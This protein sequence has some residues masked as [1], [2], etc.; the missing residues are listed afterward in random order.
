MSERYP[1]RKRDERVIRAV[2]RLLKQLACSGVLEPAQLVSA[3]KVLHVLSR[4]PRTTENVCVT[5]ELSWQ[6]KQEGCGSTS[7]WQFSV[8]SD[9]LNLS[10]G[11]SEYT[12]GVGSDSFTTMSWSARLGERTDYDGSWD[13]SWMQR[14][15]QSSDTPVHSE[16]FRGCSISVD[17]DDNDLL[18]DSESS[19]EEEPDISLELCRQGEKINLSLNEWRA[20]I[21]AFKQSGWEAGGDLDVYST[22]GIAIGNE[23]GLAMHEAGNDL[24][25]MIDQNPALAQSVG[26]DMDLFFSLTQFVGK[27]QFSVRKSGACD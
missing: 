21:L 7:S 22:P 4:L 3:A 9:W 16:D 27:G 1:L 17:D 18:F 24:W 19:E 14:D 5:I 25:R 13:D 15:D 11:G 6:V 10:T 23:D 2:E 20:A 12:E 8:G 26:L